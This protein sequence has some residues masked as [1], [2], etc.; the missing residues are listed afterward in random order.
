VEHVDTNFNHFVVGIGVYDELSLFMLESDEFSL[1]LSLS[2][3]L[4]PIKNR[5]ENDEN[6]I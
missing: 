1:S 3:S 5:I 6:K 4:S 2:P